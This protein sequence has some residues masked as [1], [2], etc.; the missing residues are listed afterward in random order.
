MGSITRR[1]TETV[2]NSQ[3][4]VGAAT[5]SAHS[6]HGRPTTEEFEEDEEDD[7]EDDM[8]EDDELEEEEE[9]EEDDEE[10]ERQRRRADDDDDDLFAGDAPTNDSMDLSMDMDD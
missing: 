10:E 2:H 4:R 8:E 1:P 5:W 3:Q 7:E 9:E 6:P